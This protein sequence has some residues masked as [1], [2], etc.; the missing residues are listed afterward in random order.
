MAPGVEFVS[1]IVQV[2]QSAGCYELIWGGNALQ[3]AARGQ[4]MQIAG[5]VGGGWVEWG[6]R[7]THY[8][9]VMHAVG[10]G[11][12]LRALRGEWV[13]AARGAYSFARVVGQVDGVGG[14]LRQPP[15]AAAKAMRSSLRGTPKGIEVCFGGGLGGEMRGG[16]VHGVVGG[17][18]A[19][20]LVVGGV[21]GAD[22]LWQ[23]PYDLPLRPMAAVRLVDI[24]A[25]LDK[26]R[27]Q[28]VAPGDEP[29]G[30]VV[31]LVVGQSVRGVVG[32]KLFVVEFLGQIVEW[33]RLPISLLGGHQLVQCIAPRGDY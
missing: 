30:L 21:D 24:V 28:Q 16:A 32:R 2:G 31:Y 12:G 19:M 14:D 11:G 20:G 3:W 9:V 26:D 22:G 10:R 25:L 29:R 27:P 1:P 17:Y 6:S 33:A 5:V 7:H 8:A 18:M 4:H 23:V 13:F 15:T